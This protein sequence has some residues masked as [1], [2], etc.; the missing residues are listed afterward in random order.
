MGGGYDQRTAWAASECASIKASYDMSL[1]PISW[2]DKGRSDTLLKIT[3]ALADEATAKWENVESD[4]QD[5][6]MAVGAWLGRGGVERGKGGGGIG[7]A[8]GALPCP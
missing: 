1:L 4:V 7:L 2:D 3:R 5:C 8:G 6:L